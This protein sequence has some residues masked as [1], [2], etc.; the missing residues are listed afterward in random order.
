[1]HYG[2]KNSLIDQ[3]VFYPIIFSSMNKR[4]STFYFSAKRNHISFLRSN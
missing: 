3:V 2:V 4:I 1:M